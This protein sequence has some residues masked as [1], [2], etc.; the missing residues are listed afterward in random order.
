MDISVTT[1]KTGR[2]RYLT[3]LM[4]FITVVICYVDRANLAVAS[5]HIQEEFG[6]S[7]TQMGY[8]FS[9]FAWMYTLCQIPGGWFL[10][11]MG[12]R[13]T[14]FIAI[15]GWSV[16][17]LFQGFATGLLS[18]IGLRA[19]TGIFEAPAFPTN[20]RMVTSWF[21]EHER[22]SAVG[23][24]TSGQ[25]VGLAFLTP[26]LIWIQEMLSWHWVFIITGGIGIVWS[27]IWFKVYR[28]PSQTKSLGK[29]ELDYISAGGGQVDS[30]I[31]VTNKER[32]PLTRADWKLVFHRKLVGVY[33]GQ[34]AV[35]STLWFFLTWFPNYLTQEKGITALQAGFMTTVPFLAAFVGV[36]LSGWLA[37]KMVKKGVSLGV[38]RKT[39]IICGLLISTCIMGANYTND[40]VWIMT[41]MAIAFFGNGFASIT[42]SLVSSLAPMR[43]IGLTGGVFNFAGGLGGITVPL[44][45]GYL[46]Q[47]HGFAPALTYISVIT[48]IG[49]LSYILLVGEVKRVG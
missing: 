11:R 24:Y 20:N 18:L 36:L 5:A 43:L 39:P 22:A 47:T 49:A 42:W 37:D 4:I 1:V 46:A 9:A 44:V 40:P 30:D 13:M 33:I 32:R 25:F 14:Y 35:A 34:F 19:I 27:L 21:P 38:A 28:A 8:I 12:S 16:A 29:A 10:D 48:M 6:I 45:I 31:V 26:L 41:L 7:K 2:R 15:F 23:F 3:L 17:T